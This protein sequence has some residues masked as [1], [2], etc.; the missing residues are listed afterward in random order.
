MRL[1]QRFGLSLSEFLAKYT[2]PYEMQQDGMAGVE[3]R[4]VDGGTACRFMTDEGAA[5]TPTPAHRV[6]LQ[7]VALLSL[8]RQ[9]ESTDRQCCA[10][11]REDHCLGQ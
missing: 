7:P 6:S 10:I 2:V 5:S 9:D 1:K 11:V 8:R 4:P 3:L